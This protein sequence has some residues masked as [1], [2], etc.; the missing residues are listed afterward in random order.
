ED[1]IEI[2]EGRYGPYIKAGKVNAKIPK[3]TD[4]T[5]LTLE[6]CQELIEEA[7]KKPKRKWKKKK[8]SE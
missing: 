3:D 8:K 5:T 4:P 1:V 6:Q 7:K 2:R